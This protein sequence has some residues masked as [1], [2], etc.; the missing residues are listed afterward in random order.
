MKILEINKSNIISIT[1][2]LLMT[3][4]GLMFV[5]VSANADDTGVY[6]DIFDTGPSENPYPC[7][8]GTHNGTIKPNVT[9]AV[10][11]IYTYPCPGTGGHVEYAKIY[12]DSWSIVTLP[13][14]GYT[15]DWH[16]L[17]FS[18]S[19]KLS[20][21]E[22]YNYTIIA[23]SYPQIHHTPALETAY[24]WINCSE[25]VDANGK[26]YN[27][28]I[29]A[30]RLEGEAINISKVLQKSIE[31]LE[32]EQ[33]PTGEWIGTVNP[34]CFGTSLNVMALLDYGGESPN[35][36]YIQKSV[37]WLIN[38]QNEDGGWGTSKGCDSRLDTTI[39]VVL[40]LNKSGILWN[41]TII[42]K[43]LDFI[44]GNDGFDNA[45]LLVTK[46]YLAANG[47][48]NW[49]QVETP[50]PIECILNSTCFGSLSDKNQFIKIT[51]Y[52]IE[53]RKMLH[54]NNNYSTIERTAMNKTIEWLIL[55]HYP[56]GSWDEGSATYWVFATLMDAGALNDTEIDKT[57][58]W[59]K[60]MQRIDGS[61]SNLIDLRMGDTAITLKALRSAGLSKSSNM[62]NN[63][64][65]YLTN[66][67]MEDGSWG[68]TI[69][70]PGDI[71]DTALVTSALID[72]GISKDSDIINKSISHLLV[73]QDSS[74]GWRTYSTTPVADS[75]STDVTSRVIIALIKSG[76]NPNS[77]EIQRGIDW[78][79]Q[80]QN[81]NGTW[82][83]LWFIGEVYGTSYA[84]QALLAAD[85]SP[86][87]PELHKSINGLKANQHLD[88]GWGPE[89]MSTTEDTSLAICALLE[90]GE[91]PC[92]QTIQ[93]GISWLV[94]NQNSD[95]SWSPALLGVL[96]QE[97]LYSDTM[98]ANAYAVDA[99]GKYKDALMHNR[100]RTNQSIKGN[101]QNDYK[102]ANK[103]INKQGG[104]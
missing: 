1:M 45:Q 90:S 78:L 96:S 60:N 55:N 76:I 47:F 18:D 65:N 99:L 70:Y 92:S 86:T 98:H 44:D 6:L 56:D 79:L 20:A 43:G 42:E 48:I 38:N 49:T 63:G 30:I 68:W 32:K 87:T 89:N 40:A 16:N 26:R 29:P 31:Y 75:L 81:E 53:L 69:H 67:Q 19:F 37:S 101:E 21:G 35:S 77:T 74:G 50:L 23:G 52:S 33:Y 66:M 91:S 95:G 34:S 73:M 85:I 17:T 94:T 22:T 71:D 59:I 58:E 62:I 88:G 83:G 25:F 4:I 80:Q 2:V 97:E 27:N 3:A 14:E 13:W 11:K 46:S 12:N 61:L 10:S 82:T 8:F 103:G 102:K 5:S 100:C 93:K 104:N 41:N 51:I 15:G 84:V 28:W 54:Q 72:A 9:I 36:T 64:T 57:I 24:G 7:I 39:L